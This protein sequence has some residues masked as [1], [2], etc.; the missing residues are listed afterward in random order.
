VTYL[1]SARYSSEDCPDDRGQV[2][3]SVDNQELQFPIHFPIERASLPSEQQR[4]SGSN[5]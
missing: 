1:D 4:P 2:I 3:V 5:G